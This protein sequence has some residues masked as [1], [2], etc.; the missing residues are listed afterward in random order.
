MIRGVVRHSWV[1]NLAFHAGEFKKP[2]RGEASVGFS[3]GEPFS[4][5]TPISKGEAKLKVCLAQ[6]RMEAEERTRQAEFYLQLQIR[7]LEIEAD[8]EVKMRRLEIEG[9][10]AASIPTVSVASASASENA[11][12]GLRNSTFDVS[13]NLP[14]V[15]IFRE[16]EVDNYF[17]AFERIAT[18]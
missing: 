2:A 18:S 9:A 12:L 10:K 5:E 13:K 17:G 1:E 15:P 14:L 11:T 8:K 6:I 4:P 16:S 3:P 7:K